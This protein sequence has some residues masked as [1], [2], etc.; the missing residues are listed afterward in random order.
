MSFG[1]ND[2]LVMNLNLL[3]LCD[4]LQGLSFGFDDELVMNLLYLR[5]LL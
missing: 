2:V 4:F 1:F 5:D 3:F